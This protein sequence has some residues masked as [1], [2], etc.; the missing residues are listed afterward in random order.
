MDR[1]LKNVGK[2][3]TFKDFNFNVLALQTINYR[4]K[5]CKYFYLCQV[6]YHNFKSN[7]DL[8]I[9]NLREMYIFFWFRQ[10][11]DLASPCV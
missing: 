8:L 1:S 5:N 4:L 2:C 7:V 11:E 6:L 10:V 9:K 3:Y